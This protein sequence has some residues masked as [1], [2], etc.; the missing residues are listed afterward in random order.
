MSQDSEPSESDSSPKSLS[1][2]TKEL[3]SLK[4][5]RKQRK[6]KI[7]R[8]K[9]SMKTRNKEKSRK[10]RVP[11]LEVVDQGKDISKKNF[12]IKQPSFILL[13]TGTLTC[14][15]TSSGHETLPKRLYIF[16][17][18][19]NPRGHGPFQVLQRINDNAYR[20]NLPSD[21][22]VSNTFNVSDLIPF[23]GYDNEE[24]DPT[25]LRTNPSQEGGDDGAW[26]KGPITGAM[27]RSIQEKLDKLKTSG[28]CKPKVLFIWTTLS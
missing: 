12:L 13:C 3:K 4:L 18:K 28:L 23:T 20:S 22:G 27:P 14:T 25:D 10:K 26:A 8:E 21:N 1:S 7:E 5:W 9:K 6:K 2:I 16:M 15:A 17:S 24:V 11:S 19:L